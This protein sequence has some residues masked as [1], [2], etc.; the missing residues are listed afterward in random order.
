MRHALTLAIIPAMSISLTAQ[1]TGGIQ[2]KITD[3]AGKPIPGATVVLL[4]SGTNVTKEVKTKENGTY[5]LAG[6]FSSEY[7][8]S[9]KADGFVT[10]KKVDRIP[11]GGFLSQDVTLYT[12]E[13]AQEENSKTDP[14]AKAENEAAKSGNAGAA[15]YNEA[16]ALYGS[17]KF[18]EA[19]PLL[20]TAFTSYQEALTK[21]KD[22]TTKAA[23]E[24]ALSTVQRVYGV[25][26]F[27][28]GK[29]DETRK[30]ELWKKSEGLL[31][32]VLPKLPETNPQ[33]LVPVLKT[34][35]ALA[36]DKKDQAN[37][38]KYQTV[39]D[40]VEPPNPKVDYNKAVDAFNEGKL[41][42]AKDYL[43]RSLQKDPK[44][45]KAYYLLG[46]VEYSNSN[47]KA[48]KTCLLKYLELEPAGDKASDVKAMLDD[49]SLKRIK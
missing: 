17:Q 10:T 38:A 16:I 22:E 29:T 28:V 21:T 14:K 31:L 20:E 44:F 36:E 27:E 41:K 18:N 45:A 48:T 26:L 35:Q 46:M 5:F 40:R 47:L 34:L 24:S 4:R 37:V 15:A 7:E 13:Q 25:T 3:K 30:V 1:I 6:V 39:I 12:P 43:D 11:M 42:E 33:N 23:A 8:I 9:F 2:G 49:P 19:L 32:E